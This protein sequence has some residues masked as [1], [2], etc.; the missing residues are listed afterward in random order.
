MSN[1]FSVSVS[2]DVL[3][4]HISAYLIVSRVLDVQSQPVHVS[5]GDAKSLVFSLRANLQRQQYE[6]LIEREISNSLQGYN[7]SLD[8][9]AKELT[10]TR[11][12]K[13][14]NPKPAKAEEKAAA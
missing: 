7:V 2:P 10:V 13:A 4:K 6:R 3:D 9:S 8:W 5:G 11:A 1:K 12:N 14:K